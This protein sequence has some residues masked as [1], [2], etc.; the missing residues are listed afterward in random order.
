MKTVANY[1]VLEPYINYQINCIS[2]FSDTQVKS[3]M[4]FNPLHMRRTK[5]N[6]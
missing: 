5:Y 1:T 3:K 4:K 2:L 6:R